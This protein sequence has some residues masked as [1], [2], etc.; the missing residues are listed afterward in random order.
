MERE[1]GSE[2]ERERERETQTCYTPAM[3]PTSL[4]W[5]IGDGEITGEESASLTAMNLNFECFVS[6]RGWR[7]DVVLGVIPYIR[8]GYYWHFIILAE[9]A[10]AE[11]TNQ[12][13]SYFFYFL[14]EFRKKHSTESFKW[15]IKTWKTNNNFHLHWDGS[16][17][18]TNKQDLNR[19]RGGWSVT[20]MSLSMGSTSDTTTSYLGI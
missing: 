2:R 6:R 8:L 3:D 10:S 18:W 13:Q 1:R 14:D 4:Q 7:R 15:S 9:S 11:W 16:S 5:R 19:A 12:T 17:K 20:F